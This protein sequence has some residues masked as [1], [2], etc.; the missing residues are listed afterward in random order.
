MENTRNAMNGLW[1]FFND[2]DVQ[3]PDHPTLVPDLHI[4][5]VPHGLGVWLRGGPD[6]VLL[7]GKQIP[8]IFNFL[9]RRLDGKSSLHD[10][11]PDCP[12]HI[13]LQD[14]LQTVALLHTKGLLTNGSPNFG[15]RHDSRSNADCL[16]RQRIYWG[17][18]VGLTMHAKYGD[19]IQKRI[20]RASL[21]VIPDGLFGLTVCEILARSGFRHIKVIWCGEDEFI[22]DSIASLPRTTISQCVNRST[23]ELCG[24]TRGVTRTADL[25]IVAMR[26]AP[27]GILTDLNRIFLDNQCAAIFSHD[28]GVEVEV[29]PFV[30]PYDT[31]CY[32]CAVLR[33]TSSEDMAVES[34]LYDASL[35]SN[36]E[37][38]EKNMFGE[39]IAAAAGVA[40][41]IAMEAIRV[42]AK[43]A[44]PQLLNSTISIN[45][46]TGNWKKH[47]L[48]RVPRCPEC[49]GGVISH[50]DVQSR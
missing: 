37:E 21:A 4:F 8:E 24:I 35:A 40:S 2:P 25:A 30:N 10:I 32:F 47:R 22:L 18:K 23:E 19:E 31:S 43:V 3:F 14:L 41:L 46:L 11:L 42:T 26:N 48:L 16:E 28:D 49:G 1:K 29:G 34:Y 13:S 33:R 5:Q 20:E 17:R 50:A 38:E 6:H 9:S 15:N 12:P 27:T 36:A 7:R 44:T 45:P 39:S